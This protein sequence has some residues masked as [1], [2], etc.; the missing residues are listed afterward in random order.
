MLHFSRRLIK[1]CKHK[2]CVVQP[3]LLACGVQVCN[4]GTVVA[5]EGKDHAGSCWWAGSGEGWAL[6]LD[7]WTREVGWLDVVAH[8]WD[9]HANE[10][11]W[12]GGSCHQH[13]HGLARHGLECGG[14][15]GALLAAILVIE[16]Q[17]YPVLQFIHFDSIWTS[18][19]GGA[20]LSGTII[21]DTL[22]APNSQ[23]VTPIST[24]LQT[25]DG[26]N[27]VRDQS[28]RGTRSRLARA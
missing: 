19:S 21:R 16:L 27:Q 8:T 22:K 25:P 4:I 23:L 18:K 10:R 11:M 7:R 14:A 20:V 13:G 3:C 17:N 12:Q 28:I 26:C 2:V 9:T 24:K 5:D 15:R 6:D 1:G